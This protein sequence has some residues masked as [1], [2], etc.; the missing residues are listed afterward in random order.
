MSLA[1]A[2]RH[3]PNLLSGLRLA[4]ALPVAWLI[5]HGD[6]QWA[7][8][9][10]VLGSASDGVDGW[11]ARRYGWQSQLGGWLDPLA[12]KAF[13]LAASVALALRGD[14]AW[15]LL[16]LMAVRD[17]VIVSGAVAFHLNY[18][19]LRAAPTMLGKLTTFALLLLVIGLLAQNAGLPLPAVLTSVLTWLGALL[20]IASGADYVVRWAAKA[21]ALRRHRSQSSKEPR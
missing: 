14:L 7:L 11:L 9:A 19:P 12:D 20:I 1:S 16:I 17:T 3:L 15:A 6:A 4:A 13:V 8:L 2:L 18:A 10:F 21:H 5:G